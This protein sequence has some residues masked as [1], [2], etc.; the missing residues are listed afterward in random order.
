V[1]C[2]CYR[3]CDM[4][5]QAGPDAHGLQRQQCGISTCAVDRLAARQSRCCCRHG[6]RPAMLAIMLLSGAARRACT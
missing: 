4:Q 6:W 2:C 3:Y 1:R 5:V